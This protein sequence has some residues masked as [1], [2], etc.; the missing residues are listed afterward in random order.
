MREKSVGQEVHTFPPET[1][2][3]ICETEYLHT[4][5]SRQKKQ[6]KRNWQCIVAASRQAIP[7]H[8]SWVQNRQ[9]IEEEIIGV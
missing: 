7:R 2:D 8:C 9:C 5:Y 4:E 1:T 6:R 3:V